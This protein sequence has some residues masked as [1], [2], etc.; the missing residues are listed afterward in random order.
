MKDVSS[1]INTHHLVETEVLIILK[2]PANTIK[3]AAYIMT[4]LLCLK[5]AWVNPKSINT[6]GNNTPT[7]A[8]DRLAKSLCLR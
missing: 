1:I 8:S 7:T 3:N 6:N 5:K 4:P 2:Y